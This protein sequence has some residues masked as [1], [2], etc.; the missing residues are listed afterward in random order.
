MDANGSGS[1]LWRT[2]VSTMSNVRVLLPQ[3]QTHFHLRSFHFT[4]NNNVTGII[5][6]FSV[7]ISIII[8]ITNLTVPKVRVW[9]FTFH[10][11]KC[12]SR[13]QGL[14]LS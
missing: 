11:I 3:Y 14:Y 8:I 4:F 1:C 10:E 6:L 13:F 7:T 5:L 9:F 2:L 12:Q